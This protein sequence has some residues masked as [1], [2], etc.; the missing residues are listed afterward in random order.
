MNQ[1]IF[2]QVD[3]T[4]LSEGMALAMSAHDAYL[5]GRDRKAVQPYAP[6]VQPIRTEDPTM[7]ILRAGKPVAALSM[8]VGGIYLVGVAVV[9]VGAAIMA[10]VAANA[11]YIGGGA[12]GIALV[13]GFFA[14]RSGEEKTTQNKTS[15]A[16][17]INVVV[18]VAGQNVSNG[19]K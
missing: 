19:T 12:L 15:G 8:L 10:F 6:P 2:Q 18:N 5:E 13:S 14:S 11:W 3:P 1:P 16:P 4:L 7:A 17:T 9:S